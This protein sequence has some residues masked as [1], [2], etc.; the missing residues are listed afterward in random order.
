MAQSPRNFRFL[1]KST[2]YS[3]LALIPIFIQSA[4]ADVHIWTNMTS[5]PAGQFQ[6]AAVS[7]DGTIMVASARSA[8]F[9]RSVNSGS[10]WTQTSGTAS[11]TYLFAMSIDGSK[12]FAAGKEGGY[13]YTSTNSGSTW[14]ARTPGVT[15]QGRPCMSDDGQIIM[16][17][18]WGGFPR[19]S[20]DGGATWSNVTGLSSGYYNGCAMSQDGSKRFVILGSG[21]TFYRSTD[22]G[23]TWSTLTLPY[24]AW[25]DVATS[26]DGS[27][28]F[29]STVSYDKV[30]KSINSGQSFSLV[31]TPTLTA[32]EYLAISGD[33]LNVVIFD[34]GAQ[35]K[36][37]TD[38]GGNW[39]SETSPGSKGWFAGDIS[40]DGTKIVAPVATNGNYVFKS[41]LIS[42]ATLTL[43]SGQTDVLYFRVAHTLTAATNY[44]G[45]VTFFANGKRIGGCISIPT[46][47]LVATCNYKPSVIGSVIITGRSV[48]TTATYAPVQIELLRTSIKPRTG[49]R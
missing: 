18:P 31:A 20:Q 11:G 44:P 21:S 40:D 29:L 7:N 41:G 5:L 37:S 28:V 34:N 47:S 42:P 23:S 32:P 26:T 48:P 2:A 38:G 10:S 17:T 13:N 12:I 25:S 1:K 45:K 16:V 19:V 3:L 8:F 4:A 15:P 14:T 49:T 39:T 36:I 27:V 30:Y 9:Q 24:S 33:A 22:S 6:G 46:I 35:L 43:S